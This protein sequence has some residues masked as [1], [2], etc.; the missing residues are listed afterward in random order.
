VPL[1]VITVANAATTVVDANIVKANNAPFLVTKLPQQ[2]I[3]CS[4]TLHVYVNGST[5]SNLNDGLT[6]KTAFQTIQYA[7]DYIG[8]RYDLAKQLAY[9][10]VADGTYT[11]GAYV[12]GGNLFGG[13][14]IVFVGNT[15]T[16]ANC[17]ISLPAGGFCFG[18]D[19]GAWVTVSGFAVEAPAGS[20]GA[21]WTV[22]GVGLQS[23]RAAVL[24]FD[25]VAFGA[26][27]YAHMATGQ[28]G[29]INLAASGTTYSIYGNTLYHMV[30]GSSGGCVAVPNAVCTI[31]TARA[32][33]IF[34]IA[35]SSGLLFAPGWAATGAGV[36]GT[37]GQ[38]YQ[39]TNGGYIAIAGGGASFFPGNVAGTS[40]TGYY[41]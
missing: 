19:D 25:H 22:P 20:G 27:S 4:S 3:I 28:N 29:S 15:T 37:T 31:A 8:Y 26:C 33:T 9:V 32:F 34:G 18:A 38:R 16:P 17:K 14:Q 35:D 2:K 5:G 24:F 21:L 41:G 12:F 11:A 10:H 39:A 36:A 1:W 30:S 13:N 7:V 23:W 6:T 40:T